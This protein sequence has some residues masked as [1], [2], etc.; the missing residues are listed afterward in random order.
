MAMKGEKEAVVRMLGALADLLRVT[1]DRKLPH[2]VPLAE[3]LAIADGYVAIQTAR[4]PD[5]LTVQKE[6]A[7]E[8]LDVLVPTMIL[9]P[10][11]ENAIQHGVAARP[12]PGL[13]SIHASRQ[14]AMLK[15]E[16]RDTGPG[17]GTETGTGTGTAAGD[18]AAEGGI[19]LGNTRTRLE[20][21]YGGA[22]R[23]ETGNAAGGGA[24]VAVA[25]P[26]RTR[27]GA[28]VPVIA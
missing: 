21:L 14:G 6:I 3:E 2:E 22:Q 1:L 15:L 26:W 27:A 23:L 4:F 16:V 13:V 17:F 24:F 7:P 19:G 18:G 9:Q 25:V 10:L 12:G 5:R 20:H 28:A 8:A 11:L